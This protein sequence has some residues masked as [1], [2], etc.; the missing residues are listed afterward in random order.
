[1][2]TG[3]LTAFHFIAGAIA[4]SAARA[5]AITVPDLGT[6][7]TT[8]NGGSGC[9]QVTNPNNN[10][11]DRTGSTTS[12]NPAKGTAI[13]AWATGSTSAGSALKGIAEGSGEGVVGLSLQGG[14]GVFGYAR[15][16]GTSRAGV[17]GFAD[18]N[19]NGPNGVLA[20]STNVEAT[21]ALTALRLQSYDLTTRAEGAL[22][23]NGDAVQAV[24]GQ[25]AVEAFTN[26]EAGVKGTGT[27]AGVEG[28]SDSG[29]GVTGM[30][31][32]GWA[33][34]GVRGV[35]DS[36]SGWGVY[37]SATGA[38]YG[39]YGDNPDSSGWAGIF[40]GNVYSYGTYQGSD[41]RLKKDV[42]DSNYGFR[43]LSKL[44]PVTYKWNRQNASDATQ[45]GLI[46]Q[47]VRTAIPEVVTASGPDGMLGVNYTALIPVVIKAI[48]EQQK[49]IQ[50][51][52]S[53]IDEL[54]RKTPAVASSG[55][56]MMVLP[57]SFGIFV[58]SVARRRNRKDRQ[59]SRV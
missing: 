29:D 19:G 42:Q 31:H 2:R 8:T 53:R 40:N 26:G 11:T 9:F 30:S 21:F 58:G 13:N 4:L 52:Q 38:G 7:C 32:G 45:I 57:L 3:R 27:T 59:Q 5:D 44:R 6:A 55:A 17:F 18:S 41:I 20:I 34:A 1:M 50:A 25:F 39:V 22:A 43:E 35:S 15:D 16:G 47:E 36:G 24:G 12:P 46:A 51:Q 33:T 48:Q 28:V 54:S 49:A 37:G 10:A 23:T 56:L 14:D